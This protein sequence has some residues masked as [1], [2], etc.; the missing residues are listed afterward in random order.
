MCC[1]T[2]PSGAPPQDSTSSLRDQSTGLAWLPAR[3]WAHRLRS[4]CLV[5]VLSVPKVC[6]RCGGRQRDRHAHK[7]MRAVGSDGPAAWEAVRLR[8]DARHPLGRR[9]NGPARQAFRANGFSAGS[10]WAVRIPRCRAGRPVTHLGAGFRWPWGAARSRAA[11]W[12]EK[13]VVG[14]EN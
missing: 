14:G 1:R 7:V 3:G 2:I 4:L 10:R 8:A 11:G 6:P 5:P 13:G 12:S 9:G